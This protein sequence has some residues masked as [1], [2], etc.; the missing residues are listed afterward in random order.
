MVSFDTDILLCSQDQLFVKS[1]YGP[2]RDCGY[3]VD[4]TEHPSE[5]V[6]C[7]MSKRYLSVILDSRDFGIS[8]V[9]AVDI[10]KSIQ[11]DIRAIFVG[12]K[13]SD[14]D[15]ETF[16]SLE[17]VDYLKDLFKGL[18]SDKTIKRRVLRNDTEGNNHQGF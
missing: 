3:I 12:L 17:A 2:L 9:D 7:V 8:V 15:L 5:A 13:K 11:P 6:R 4:I 18:M 14:F 16:D 10:M 1:I